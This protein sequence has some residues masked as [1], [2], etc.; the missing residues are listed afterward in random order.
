MCNKRNDVEANYCNWCGAR[1]DPR[2]VTG[3]EPCPRI[4]LDMV[5]PVTHE[6][7]VALENAVGNKYRRVVGEKP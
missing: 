1:L 4:Y 2:R 5:H 3:Q 6:M 7:R